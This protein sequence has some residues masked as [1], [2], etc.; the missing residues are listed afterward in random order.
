MKIN[1]I[2]EILMKF[3]D[4]TYTRPDYQIIEQKMTG[5]TKQFAEAT[6][7]KTALWSSQGYH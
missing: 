5:L 6:D 4:Y 3:T 1:D 2:K 7:A